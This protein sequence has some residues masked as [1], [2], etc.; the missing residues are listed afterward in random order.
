MVVLRVKELFPGDESAPAVP[1]RVPAV[2]EEATNDLA[3]LTFDAAK[4]IK[5]IRGRRAREEVSGYLFADLLGME[6]LKTEVLRLGEAVRRAA[7]DAK[8]EETRLKNA[9]S[10]KKSY[11]RK[12]AEKDAELAVRLAAEIEEI[13]AATAAA[14]RDV[15]TAVIKP[16]GLPDRNT[17]LVESRPPPKPAPAAPAA[18]SVHVCSDSCT[19]DMCPRAREMYEMA[20]SSEAALAIVTAYNVLSLSRGGKDSFFDE[21]LAHA[22]VGYAHALR[23]LKDAYPG[24]FCGFSQ[25]S[26]KEVVGWTIR[27]EATGLAMPAARAAAKRVGF[28]LE[29][30][31]AYCAERM[32]LER[33]HGGEAHA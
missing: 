18:P 13:D 31:V 21:K 32:A 23:R 15:Q 12:K 6:M 30:N 33:A 29:A 20:T 28:P 3:V 5:V 26:A 25:N 8:D 7:I 24:E 4:K 1:P 27:V 11:L 22:E 9:A 19:E 2:A 14:C 17:V 10:A 16:A